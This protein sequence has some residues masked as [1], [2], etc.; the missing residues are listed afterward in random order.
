M[1]SVDDRLTLWEPTSHRE[2]SQLIV[3]L[4]VEVRRLRYL[5]NDAGMEWKLLDTPQV[6]VRPE[7]VDPRLWALFDSVSKIHVGLMPAPKKY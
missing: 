4:K 3:E 5:V 7:W 2:R 1:S 6:P